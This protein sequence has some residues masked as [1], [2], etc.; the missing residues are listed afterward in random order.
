MY[1]GSPESMRIE[2]I[3]AE[4]EVFVEVISETIAYF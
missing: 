2:E 4:Y 3:N 1:K